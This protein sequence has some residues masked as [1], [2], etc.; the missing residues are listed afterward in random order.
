MLTMEIYENLAVSLIEAC[1]CGDLDTVIKLIEDDVD[2]HNED[3]ALTW[4]AR[5]GHLSIIRYLIE[6]CDSDIHARNDV[7]L[8]W[9]AFFEHWEVVKYLVEHGADINKLADTCEIMGKII[10]WLESIDCIQYSCHDILW[11]PPRGL[12]PNFFSRM[13]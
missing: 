10:P 4:S 2:I 12:M 3:E 9:S 6:E 5:Y 7:A 8:R 11:K 13:I 1:K